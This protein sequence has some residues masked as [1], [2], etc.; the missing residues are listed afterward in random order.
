GVSVDVTRMFVTALDQQPLRLARTRRR[1]HQG[2]TPLQ[3]VTRQFEVQ[4]ARRD[5]L[6]RIAFRAPGAVV[7]QGDMAGAVMPFGNLALETGVVQRMVL[8][9]HGKAPFAGAHRRAFR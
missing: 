9:L 7:E 3:A 2:E 6:E 1:P 5:A 4:L 8:D